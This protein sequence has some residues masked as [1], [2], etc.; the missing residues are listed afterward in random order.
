MLPQVVVLIA[1]SAFV[2]PF[3][4]RA[5]PERAA[6]I[7]AGA[8][9]AGLA[10]YAL[11][12]NVGYPWVAT[13]LVLVAAGMRVV[14]VVAALNVLRGLPDTRTTLGTALADTA[15]QVTSG[16]GT[17]VT[18]TIIAALFTG[19]IAATHWSVAQT[20]QFHHAVTVAGLTLTALAAALV[21]FGIWRSRRG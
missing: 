11:L 21:A 20:T 6:W 12:G 16:I 7:S 18:G 17:A 13:A 19:S 8:V 15:A 3:V 1:G 14:G 2:D 4:A 10:V 9:M 5:G